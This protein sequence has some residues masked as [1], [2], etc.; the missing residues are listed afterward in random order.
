MTK[1]VEINDVCHL[2][3]LKLLSEKIVTWDM[4]AYHLGLTEGDTE[5]IKRNYP[6]DYKSQKYQMLREWKNKKGQCAT[7]KSLCVTL[8]NAKEASLVNVLLDKIMK[9]P[10]SLITTTLQK[11]K[12]HLKVR[13]SRGIKYG[14]YTWPPLPSSESYINLALIKRQNVKLN[15]IDD[16]YTKSTI[17]HC[18]DDRCT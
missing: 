13:Y 18:P 7:Y 9:T 12:N 8:T 2:D 1:I 5:V 10:V 4:I 17:H 6:N 14:Q 16:S 3:H 11:C 15:K